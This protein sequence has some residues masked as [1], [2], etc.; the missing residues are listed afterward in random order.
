MKKIVYQF[1]VVFAV[2]CIGV[3]A[4][5]AP[6]ATDLQCNPL[7]CVNDTDIA[8]GAVTNAKIADGA[9]TDAKITGP[10]SA[11]KLEKPANVVVVAA[12]GGDY[13][14]ISEALT[15]ITPT[16]ANRYV[17][18]VMPGTYNESVTM[19]SYVDLQGAGMDVTTINYE[20]GNAIMCDNV[21]NV[22]ISGFTIDGYHGIHNR[23]S[24]PTI[25]WNVIKTSYQ[26]PGTTG[27]HNESASPTIKDNIFEK[28]RYAAIYNDQGSSP[29]ISNN[30]I[31]GDSS[32]VRGILDYG[33]STITN[34]IIKGAQTGI[35]GG[36]GIISGNLIEGNG[37]GISNGGSALTIKNNTIRNNTGNGISSGGSPVTISS[38]IISGNAG[39]GIAELSDWFEPSTQ[40]IMY[41]QIKDNSASDIYIH[42]GNA[43]VKNISFNVYNTFT[44]SGA[45]GNYN[46]KSDGTPA[47]MQ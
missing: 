19:K 16:A 23:Q 2:M 26:Y 14:S 1:V 29:I 20:D 11:S 30:E 44:G 3:N 35:A 38:N 12:T 5:A 13:A 41:N 22:T 37:T 24:S 43:I 6:P 28:W 9:V 8:A 34:N 45:I 32:M 7:G 36:A 33:A 18:K 15:A 40:L 10:I 17:V 27:I 31:R 46:L 4:W 21:T 47:P 42:P 39:Y 25:M